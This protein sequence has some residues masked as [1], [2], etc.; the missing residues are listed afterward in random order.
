MDYRL[1]VHDRAW[2]GPRGEYEAIATSSQSAL[3]ELVALAIE[4]GVFAALGMVKVQR[5]RAGIPDELSLRTLAVLPFVEAMGL[6]AAAGS[7]FQDAAIR[8]PSGDSIEQ[9]QNGF[10]PRRG[11]KQEQ[12]TTVP[13]HVEVVRQELARIDLERLGHFRQAW[14]RELFARQLVKGRVSAID[15]SRLPDRSRV[16]GRLNG[17]EARCLWLSWRVL[18]GSESEKGREAEVGRAVVE[19]VRAAGGEAAIEWLLMEALCADGPLVAWLEYGCQIQALTRLSEDRLCSADLA[20]RA[21]TGLISRQTHTDVRYRKGRKPVRQVTV[22]MA[23]ALISWAFSPGHWSLR[24]PPPPAYGWLGFGGSTPTTPPRW[25]KGRLS[26]P[27]PSTRPGLA[28]ATDAKAGASKTAASGNSKKA[29][30]WSRTDVTAT[31]GPAPVVVFTADALAVFH[32]EELM[33]LLACSPK[34]SLRRL[35]SKDPPRLS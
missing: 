2:E 3:D 35:S 33:A 1:R 30:T 25:R 29:G 10:N 19:E 13:Y 34:H 27:C 31:Y 22:M 26:A 11:A 15:G 23:E 12:K 20:G 17:H 16:A 21:R 32:I 5:E 28:I 4:G 9:V 14:V 18:S 24:R 8:L 6:S 7:L